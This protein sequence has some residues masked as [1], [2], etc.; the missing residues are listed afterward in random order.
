MRK[1]KTFDL[2]FISKRTGVLLILFLTSLL[3]FLLFI[4]SPQ[5]KSIT[6]GVTFSKPFA[7]QLG[8]DWRA[9]YLAVLD[10]LK[11]KKLR[12]P[13]YWNEIEKT[14]EEFSFE[15]LDWQIAQAKQRNVDVTL[16]L[17]QKQP[18]W[19][20]CHLPLWAQNKNARDREEAVLG[21]IITTVQR[22][23]NEPSVK[24][25]QVENEPFLEYGENCLPLNPQFLDREVALVR[26]LDPTRPIMLT[27]SGELNNWYEP[28]KRADILGITMYRVV[29]DEKF[30]YVHYPFDYIFYR[31]K[32]SIIKRST[33]AH[34]IIV[35][36][37]QAEPWGSKSITEMSLEEQKKSMNV[38]EFQKNVKFT[39]DAGYAEVY[40]WGAEWWYWLKTTQNDT[41]MWES[42]RSLFAN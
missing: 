40:L 9:T 24:V 39:R 1:I 32:G 22:Y 27:D 7:E 6:Y 38:E 25:W 31:L 8:L 18:R 37:L 10:E 3:A 42:A 15:D 30:G 28:A 41:S 19:P 13:A 33:S 14:E 5:N 16:V 11:V 36:E 20:E 26:G 2:F 35:T 17:G 12:L 29:W 4:Y 21:A 23:K 34:K